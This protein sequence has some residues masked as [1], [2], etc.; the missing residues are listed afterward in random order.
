MNK[1]KIRG[2]LAKHAWFPIKE[3]KWIC[4]KDRKQLLMADK[5]GYKTEYAFLGEKTLDTMAQHIVNF[6]TKE[7]WRIP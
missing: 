1:R 2:L 6:Y 4:T 7:E 5:T 3:D